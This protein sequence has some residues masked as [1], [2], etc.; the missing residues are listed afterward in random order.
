MESIRAYIRRMAIAQNRIDGI[1]YRSAKA[2]GTKD[3]TLVLLYA[4][5]DG[6]PHTQ[7]QI[8]QE[9]LIPKT[10]LNTVVRECV[11][12]GYIQLE[13][14]ARE[15][16]VC[17]TPVGEAYAKRMLKPLYAAEEAAMG[18][19]IPGFVEAL[20]RFSYR[21]EAEFQHYI[22]QGEHDENQDPTV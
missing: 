2:L 21:F 8:C 14:H 22:L 1:Y 19:V 5:D 6:V 10:T 15:K 4:L 9:W 13:P 17:L 7:K 18:E 16:T 20:E 12:K 3:N 11:E